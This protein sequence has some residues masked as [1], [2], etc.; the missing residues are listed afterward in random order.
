MPPELW[1][2]PYRIPEAEA[3]VEEAGEGVTPP[4]WPVGIVRKIE[5]M[6]GAG[7][8]SEF[9]VVR[10]CRGFRAVL[11]VV[12]AVRRE[13]GSGP[14]DQNHNPRHPVTFPQRWLEGGGSEKINEC[15]RPM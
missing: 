14:G 7:E 15:Q 2:A 8:S 1:E 9:E 6:E 11:V 13:V 12:M 4:R 10:G 3:A 5:P